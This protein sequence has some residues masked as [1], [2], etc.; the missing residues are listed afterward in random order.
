VSVTYDKLWDLLAEKG[1]SRT[2]LRSDTGMTTNVLGQLGKNESVQIDILAKI[3]CLLNCKLDDIVEI[4]DDYDKSPLP[5]ISFDTFIHET[6]YNTL[7]ISSL[8]SF[9]EPV[10]RFSVEKN[11]LQFYETGKLSFDAC[12][13]LVDK[14]ASQ[15]IMISFP[16]DVVPKID[17]IPQQFS[18]NAEIASEDAF[19]IEHQQV[20][21]YFLWVLSEAY[22]R[23][24]NEPPTY[25]AEKKYI[26]ENGHVRPLANGRLRFIGISESLKN[27]EAVYPLN[28][29]CKIFD[30]QDSF[31]L[32]QASS[33]IKKRMDETL[34]T[35][36]KPEEVLIRLKYQFGLDAQTILQWLNLPQCES[37]LWA[38]QSAPLLHKAFRKLRHPSRSKYMRDALTITP[39]LLSTASIAKIYNKCK[40]HII[41]QVSGALT[42]GASLA[43]ALQPFYTESVIQKII[44]VSNQWK[45]TPAVSVEKMVLDWK[46]HAAL[47]HAGI[48]ALEDLW[49][50][51]GRYISLNNYEESGLNKIP[52]LGK[53]QVRNILLNME[54]FPLEAIFPEQSEE[55]VNYAEHI[56]SNGE[57]PDL[58]CRGISEE[59]LS[60]LFKMKYRTHREVFRDFRNGALTTLLQTQLRAG[61]IS[62]EICASVNNTLEAFDKR[63]F[64]VFH[65]S[66]RPFW[67][68]VL[69]ANP[70]FSLESI[71][72]A[73]LLGKPLR[74]NSRDLEQYIQDIF[75]RTS[76]TR[77]D[78]WVM[79]KTRLREL[80]W[81]S[82]PLELFTKTIHRQLLRDDSA[83]IVK[84]Y[85][86]ANE[87]NHLLMI[88][89]SSP[90]GYDYQLFLVDEYPMKRIDIDDK[91]VRSNI[92]DA[93]EFNAKLFES[94]YSWSDEAKQA[95]YS[96]QKSFCD[97][98]KNHIEDNSE[99][100][101]LAVYEPATLT[102]PNKKEGNVTID[103]MS[104]EDM[105]LSVRSFNCLKRANINN[106]DDLLRMTS[107]ELS[108]VR[109]MG[110]KSAEEVIHKLIMLGYDVS[111]DLRG[112]RAEG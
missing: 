77:T 104:I 62:P 8:N 58:A 100:A 34:E 3:C 17:F 109:N 5:D 92:F 78:F 99:K 97:F 16:R 111:D 69:S 35:L 56:A 19:D 21:N 59:V 10:I 1:I 53:D 13:E 43:D 48:H 14:L 105:D 106:T 23:L 31:V 88:V 46:S 57:V 76:A 63:V 89:L 15:G 60:T 28:L 26:L 91:Q 27:A 90:N 83:K 40:E 2:E 61:L 94:T 68:S 11:L 52:G 108:T 32:A 20:H 41:N 81:I 79:N 80:V 38:A 82:W 50:A 67:H 9:P 33:D 7:G 72:E 95:F 37:F 86:G 42:Q 45:E 93:V 24:K 75:P 49:E 6:Q 96:Q 54:K 112:F 29:L 51:H 71:R 22:D 101:F 98:W 70:G 73:Y 103:P 85:Y 25:S 55:I 107:H 74:C 44:S 87:I 84:A 64:P 47:E 39:H 36:K 66:T 102:A 4:Q 65:L 12:K 18:N 110:R 30:S